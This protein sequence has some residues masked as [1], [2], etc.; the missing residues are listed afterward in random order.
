VARLALVTKQ[1]VSKRLK[2]A[3]RR[4]MW[5]ARLLAGE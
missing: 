3:A 2:K 4:E 1:A 5:L